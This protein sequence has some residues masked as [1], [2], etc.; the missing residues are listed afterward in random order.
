MDWF[1]RLLL[2]I[3]YRWYDYHTKLCFS[4]HTSFSA[5]KWHDTLQNG[6]NSIDVTCHIVDR[7]KSKDRYLLIQTSQFRNRTIILIS[8][9]QQKNI[10]YQ[11]ISTI[12]CRNEGSSQVHTKINYVDKFCSVY[13]I[14]TGMQASSSH[15]R[16]RCRCHH[17]DRQRFQY[18]F[19]PLWRPRYTVESVYM[20]MVEV[21]QAE[22][23]TIEQRYKMYWF[24]F[25]IKIKMR[26]FLE[27]QISH[28]L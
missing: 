1:I 15:Y 8:I 18:R 27:N 5:E 20:V 28:I 7:K 26:W 11:F 3:L 12:C 6:W 24:F 13:E 10:L 9:F 4:F 14:L 25:S 23:V 22:S 16:C 21:I 2:C 19:Q 17:L